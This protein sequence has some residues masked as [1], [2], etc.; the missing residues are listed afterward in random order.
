[1]IRFYWHN[2]SEDA[3]GQALFQNAVTTHCVP[4]IQVNLDHKE[5]KPAQLSLVVPSTYAVETSCVLAQRGFLVYENGEKDRGAETLFYGVV[6]DRLQKA[7]TTE[8]ILIADGD[9]FQN[10]WDRLAKRIKSSG[11][12]HHDV[13]PNDDPETLLATAPYTLY[14]D[15]RTGVLD[16]S[17]AYNGKKTW[18]IGHQYD[19]KYR[20]V[21]KKAPISRVNVQIS[22]E[23][24]QSIIG[25]VNVGQHIGY[26]G[27]IGTLTDRALE[28]AWPQIGDRLGGYF[29]ADS[30]LEKITAVHLPDEYVF[31][32]IENKEIEGPDALASHNAA[33][34]WVTPCTW[35]QS[36]LIMG[37]AYQYR[38]KES[39]TFQLQAS[40]P[41]DETDGGETFLNL[42]L[43]KFI[44]NEDL[45]VWHPLG[46]YAPGDRVQ[47]EGRVYECCEASAAL[48]EYDAISLQRSYQEA[49]DAPKIWK[50]LP[51]ESKWLEPLVSDQFFPK[52]LGKE[53]LVH[54]I[55]RAKTM[56]VWNMRCLEIQ[57]RGTVHD[58]HAITLD[59][60]IV[61]PDVNDPGK[62][63]TGK[64]VS[65]TLH[66]DR[67]KQC[68]FVQITGAFFLT[69]PENKTQQ[70]PEHHTQET[71]A[72]IACAWPQPE[73]VHQDKGVGLEEERTF[74]DHFKRL[75]IANTLDQ[76]LA[77][78][79]T[80]YQTFSTQGQWTQSS[81]KGKETRLKI[82]MNPLPSR[83][84]S[85]NEINLKI[86]E[87]YCVV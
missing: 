64:V 10:Q 39:I 22:A 48:I 58:W 79:D 67:V 40:L 57:V 20:S 72:A 35:Y 28:S 25:Y 62:K 52:K 61:L 17:H 7:E 21:R 50:E 36:R 78:L 37:Y 80:L 70:C 13:W 82:V 18:D 54:S 47:H 83:K 16:T 59:D 74:G 42:V 14:W 81:V 87:T 9:A 27:V 2:G 45:P 43:P 12:Y 60:C 63:S 44:Q 73:P 32:T 86:L 24:D 46:D 8:I 4:F 75:E 84:K 71:L 11:A 85:T 68:A 3:A 26:G 76:Q 69:G 55:E 34:I 19:P 77:T 6:K 49:A 30:H 56:L 23:W 5:G 15:S 29:V 66:V 33:P 51:E 53:I 38:R 41:K 31:G 1:M 65:Y